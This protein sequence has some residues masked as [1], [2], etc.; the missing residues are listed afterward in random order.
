MKYNQLDLNHLNEVINS[1]IESV[2]KGQNE[3]NNIAEYSKQECERLDK[4]LS[5][6]KKRL[7]ETIKKVD[8]LEKL[9]KAARFRLMQVSR[10]FKKYTEEDIKVAYD[11]AKDIQI[12]LLLEKQQEM[13]LRERRDE[14]ERSLRSMMAISKRA[15]HFVMQT[16]V[17]LNF[18]KGKLESFSGTLLDM[19]Q[20]QLFA[21]S[22]IKAQEEE[23]KR[24]ARDIHD[25]PAQTMANC[26]IQIE[27][28]E[29]LFDINLDKVKEEFK[30]LKEIVRGSL[31]ELRKV[32][33][34]LRPSALDDLGLEAVARRYCT[35][36]QEETG[37]NTQFN[38]FGDK[39]RL[40]SSIEVMLFRILQEALTNVKKH[41]NAK[42]VMVKIEYLSN[43]VNLAVIDDGLGFDLN[44]LNEIN[45]GEHTG[46]ISIKE[47]AELFR[48]KIRIDS[49]LGEGTKIYVSVPLQK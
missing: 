15:E 14:L 49:S 38:M 7:C 1:T 25:G 24:V 17:A 20:K 2:E 44:I 33:F 19:T 42:N 47:R 41:S 4:E 40:D 5:A 6:I 45:G 32:I 46:L 10:E 16:S 18:L 23:R 22:I 11:N 37:I 12:K 31:K 3:I 30:G 35:E 21:S 48:G 29:R 9:E 43:H 8:D 27:I 39:K 34:N 28:C 26:L 13:Q 36:F